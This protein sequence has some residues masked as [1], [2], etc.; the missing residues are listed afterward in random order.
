MSRMLSTHGARV[1][2]ATPHTW[3][4]DL[5][6]ARSI[7]ARTQK[8]YVV[9]SRGRTVISAPFRHGDR[10]GGEDLEQLLA[11]LQEQWFCTGRER[12]G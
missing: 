3:P 9:S 10:F 1:P 2:L 11:Y 6:S 12:V 4:C 5:C 7:F 8:G